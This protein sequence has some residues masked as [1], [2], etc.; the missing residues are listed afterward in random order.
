MSVYEFQDIIDEMFKSSKPKAKPNQEVTLAEKPSAQRPSAALFKS[1]VV[2]ETTTLTDQ[3]NASVVNDDVPD[4]DYSILEEDENQ[5]EASSSAP[6]T[7]TVPET[8]SF[9][10]LLHNWENTCNMMSH[11]DEST[12]TATE[13]SSTISEEVNVTFAILFNI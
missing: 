5:F 4:M 6:S 1:K 2:E 13:N 12:T 7:Q 9:E 10:T 3:I 11:A 8:D